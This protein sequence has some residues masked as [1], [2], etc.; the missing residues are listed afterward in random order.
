MSAQTATVDF[1]P[2][3]MIEETLIEEISGSPL[4][5][6]IFFFGVESSQFQLSYVRGCGVGRKGRRKE[7]RCVA[8][9]QARKALGRRRNSHVISTLFFCF[10]LPLFLFTNYLLFSSILL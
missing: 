6:L 1:I 2:F 10:F 9:S 7:G 4:V 8:R 5:I 3:F